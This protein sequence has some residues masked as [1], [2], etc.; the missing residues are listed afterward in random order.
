MSNINLYDDQLLF[1]EDIRDQLRAGKKSV[2]AVASTGFGKTI[3]SAFIA[4]EAAAKGKTVWFLVHLKNLLNQT[5]SSFWNLKINHGLIASGKGS[6]PLPIQVATVGT[7]ANRI[8]YLTPPDVLILDECHF[9]MSPSWLKVIDK[10]KEHGTVIIGNSATPERLDGKGLGY[11]FDSMVEAIPMADLIAEGRLS[12]YDLYSV[13]NGVDYSALRTAKGD[14]KHD[15]SEQAMDKPVIT[16]DAIEH[17]KKYAFNKLTIAYC[18]SI[19]HSKHTAEQF[20]LAGIAAAHVDGTTPTAEL[21]RVISDL[22]DGKIKVLCN[23]ELMTT[24]FD[25]A[26]QVDR[27]VCIEACILLRPTKSVALAMQMIG[28]ALR[29]KDYPAIILDHAGVCVG[30]FGHGLPDDI[31]EWSLEGSKKGKKRK[32]DDEPDILINQ[33]KKCHHAWRK[34]GETECPKCFEPIEIKY[35]KV[36]EQ[37]GELQKVERDMERINAI[38]SRKQEQGRAQT[39]DDLIKLGIQRGIKKPAAWAAITLAGRRKQRPNSDDFSIANKAL[40]KIRG[41]LNERI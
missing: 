16:G 26:A 20:N 2:L 27:D 33:C 22:A 38:K 6:S 9:A 13:P 25:L 23:V 29:K 31:R 17:W 28:R 32:G 34:V 7:L 35:R 19:K 40:I 30:P 39:I 12:D 3:L 18:V 37:A 1:I 10:C 41:E 36:E 24:G 14:F 5:S 4:K 15:E 8:D 11:I 21:K